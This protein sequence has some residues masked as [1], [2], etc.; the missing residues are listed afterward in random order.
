MSS[1]NRGDDQTK[2]PF[3]GVAS[4]DYNSVDQVHDLETQN[5][6]N[7]KQ[8]HDPEDSVLAPEQDELL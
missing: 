1:L 3:Y 4:D 2:N 5:I 8:S 6:F 7:S